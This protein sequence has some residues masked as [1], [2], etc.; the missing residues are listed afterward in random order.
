L[1][2]GCRDK[3]V[4]LVIIEKDSQI[5]GKRYLET[6]KKYFLLFHKRIVKKYKLDVVMQEDNT[7][8]HTTRI[9]KE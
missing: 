7:S 2:F 8:W 1:V 3:I 5:T 9:V 6:V 4:S